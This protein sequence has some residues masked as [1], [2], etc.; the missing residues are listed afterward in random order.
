MHVLAYTGALVRL[1]WLLRVCERWQ[2]MMRCSLRIVTV[3][4]VALVK[5]ESGMHSEA[6]YLCPGPCSCKVQAPRDKPSR[7]SSRK[8]NPLFCCTTQ[9]VPSS[10]SKTPN[11]I[12]I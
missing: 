5:C 8:H 9:A 3:Y 6:I 1:D 11:H 7:Q 12:F 2:K 10:E 4:L